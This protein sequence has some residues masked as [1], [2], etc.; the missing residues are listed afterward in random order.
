MFLLLGDY[1]ESYYVFFLFLV[2][3]KLTPFFSYIFFR[4]KKKHGVL[5]LSAT[6]QEIKIKKTGGIDPIYRCGG[7]GKVPLI[8]LNRNIKKKKAGKK[9]K[10]KANKRMKLVS[11]S[12]IKLL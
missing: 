5:S 3:F 6:Q 1:Q 11:T 9:Q 7:G 4:N 2:Q 12:T 10:Q 8:R